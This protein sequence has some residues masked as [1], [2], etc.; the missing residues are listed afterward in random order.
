MYPETIEIELL[1]EDF[2][3]SSYISN[4]D[5][6]LARGINRTFE[7]NQSLKSLEGFNMVG[8]SSVVFFPGCS[9]IEMGKGLNYSILDFYKIVDIYWEDFT[10]EFPFIVTLKKA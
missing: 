10:P 3:G 8:G 4:E 1:K 5:C 7:K 2:E 6:A 9:K